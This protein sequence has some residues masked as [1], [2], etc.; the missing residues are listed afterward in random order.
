MGLSGWLR[1]HILLRQ[2]ETEGSLSLSVSLCLPLY[3]K[4]ERASHSFAP[5]VIIVAR[6]LLLL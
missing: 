1:C 6:L 5:N 3:R 2:A 4:F